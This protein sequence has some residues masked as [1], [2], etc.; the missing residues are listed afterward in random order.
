MSDYR[1]NIL[2]PSG[3]IRLAF[4]LP[5]RD[6]LPALDEAKKYYRAN[7]IE[8]WQGPRQVARIDRGGQAPIR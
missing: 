7:G 2:D 4:D 8:I 3:R 5:C 6:D 1:I